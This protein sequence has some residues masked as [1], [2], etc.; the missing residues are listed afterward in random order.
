MVEN[1]KMWCSTT[2]LHTLTTSNKFNK[3]ENISISD[4]DLIT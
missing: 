1:E 4:I 3:I 2:K